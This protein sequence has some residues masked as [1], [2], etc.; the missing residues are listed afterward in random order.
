[1]ELYAELQVFSGMAMD[2][3]LYRENIERLNSLVTTSIAIDHSRMLRGYP[4]QK[5]CNVSFAYWHLLN[6]KAI[7]DCR[8]PAT[9]AEKK[10]EAAYVKWMAEGKFISEEAKKFVGRAKWR[11]ATY[12]E[13]LNGVIDVT[14]RS[15]LVAILLHEF[16]HHRF[17]D[18]DKP[19][20]S[21]NEIIE[22][23]LRADRFA[24]ATVDK[25]PEPKEYWDIALKDGFRFSYLSASIF[26][27][28]SYSEI[29]RID[30]SSLEPRM[31]YLIPLVA[32]LVKEEDINNEVR[33]HFGPAFDEMVSG[34]KTYKKGSGR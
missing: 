34:L 22:R 26:T 7:E 1:M 28:M 19:A 9:T 27:A 3:K 18:V 29:K 6:G 33:E 15:I 17:N 13:F 21:P 20:K 24:L 23:E 25:M 16:G 14:Q 4:P 11:G 31:D 8:P 5:T 2:Q 32:A 30:P 10:F 12:Y